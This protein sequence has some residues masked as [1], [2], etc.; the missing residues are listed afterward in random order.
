MMDRD[1]E[2]AIEWDC[3]KVLRQYY[4]YVDR[5]EYDQAVKLFTPDIDWVGLGVALKGHAEILDGLHAGLGAG[6]IRH[7][8]TNTI[9]TVI[10]ENHA[11][12]RSYNILFSSPDV[13]FE[14]KQGPI[15]M[16][17][18]NILVDMADELTRTEEGWRISRRRGTAIFQR[19]PDRPVPLQSWDKGKAASKGT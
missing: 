3:H 2:R 12:A 13:R 16:E 7:C 5:H 17:G 10:D 18:A 4:D 9:V 19:N 14:E 1:Q 11:K 8:L 15:P 6:T